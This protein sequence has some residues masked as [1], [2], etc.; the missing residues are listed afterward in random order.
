MFI[1]SKK[2]IRNCNPGLLLSLPILEPA[3]KYYQ[4]PAANMI[5]TTIDLPPLIIGVDV[6]DNTLDMDLV[7]VHS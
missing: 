5:S 3:L 2:T 4:I 7:L 1:G 6:P